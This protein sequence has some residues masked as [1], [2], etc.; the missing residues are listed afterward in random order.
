MGA[1]WGEVMP[2]QNYLTPNP[3]LNLQT[4]DWLCLLRPEICPLETGFEG[5]KAGGW[6]GGAGSESFLGREAHK[7]PTPLLPPTHNR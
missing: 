7:P 6:G 3:N 4:E 5:S 2:V 1:S